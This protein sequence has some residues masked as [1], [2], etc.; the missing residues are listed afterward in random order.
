MPE[1]SHMSDSHRTCPVAQSFINLLYSLL[2]E[3]A[4]FWRVPVR[5]GQTC[6]SG[7]VPLEQ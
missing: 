1:V 6:L 3:M 5:A 2:I 4:G 7:N